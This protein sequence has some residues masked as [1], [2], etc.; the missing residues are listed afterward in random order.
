MEL[1]QTWLTPP[2]LARS[3]S[4][5]RG[6]WGLVVIAAFPFRGGWGLVVIAVFPF[7]GRLGIGGCLRHFL[8]GEALVWHK[9]GQKLIYPNQNRPQT[10]SV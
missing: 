1:V 7:Q 10:S 5:F 3:P 4:P 8:L 9:F 6:G 2:P